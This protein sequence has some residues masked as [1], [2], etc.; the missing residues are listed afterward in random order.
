VS[1]GE[2]SATLKMLLRSR[3]FL[4]EIHIVVMQALGVSWSV[5]C[6]LT[7]YAL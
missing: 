6:A 2:T 3:I 1:A 7:L 5:P 4:S